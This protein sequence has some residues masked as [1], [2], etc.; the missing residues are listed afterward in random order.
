MIRKLLRLAL[1]V[2]VLAAT[3][4]APLRA[5][6]APGRTHLDSSGMGA[7]MSMMEMMPDCPMMGI[8]A[9]G[10]QAVLRQRERLRLSE[11][12]VRRLDSLATAGERTRTRW[13]DDM[14]AIHRELARLGDAA[15]S[16][17]FRYV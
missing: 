15:D 3:A 16:R 13:T 11:A 14:R 10:P 17:V 6:D 2:S 7:M 1:G 4:V 12:Q 8:M 5:Q 9:E